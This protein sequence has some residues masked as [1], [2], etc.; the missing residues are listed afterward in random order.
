MLEAITNFT[1]PGVVT[2]LLAIIV[3]VLYRQKQTNDRKMI[4]SASEKDRANLVK[5]KLQTQF[6]ISSESISE[7]QRFSLLSDLWTREP[8]QLELSLD[9]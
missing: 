6:G 5:L 9:I 4:E 7:E 3:L 8:K 1:T 2:S